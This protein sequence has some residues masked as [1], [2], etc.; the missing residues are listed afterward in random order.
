METGHL[1]SFQICNEQFFCSEEKGPFPVGNE[2]AGGDGAVMVKQKKGKVYLV[3]AGP[4]DPGLLTLKGK[5]CLSRADVIIYDNLANRS[6]LSYAHEGCQ[7]IYVGKRG[8]CHTVSQT[9][10]NR[11][12]VDGARPR[13][14]AIERIEWPTATARDISSRS[15]KL[16]ANRER[17]RGAGRIPPVSARMRSIDE[18]YRLNSWAIWARESPF[19]QRSHIKVFWLSV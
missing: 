15:A 8:G 14:V 12:I 1:L 16:S 6:F 4:G 13:E 5:A 2:L 18:W 9:E 17:R 11:L 7:R 19:C 3:G 10:I